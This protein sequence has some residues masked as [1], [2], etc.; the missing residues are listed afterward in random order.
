[1]EWFGPDWGAPVNQ[2]CEETGTPDWRC[3][4]CGEAFQRTDRGV[5]M[6]FAG[7][8]ESLPEGACD[9]EGRRVAYHHACLLEAL[10]LD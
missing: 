1:M 10:G 3:L 5:T 8:E 9:R 7:G 4:R 6:P 2:D